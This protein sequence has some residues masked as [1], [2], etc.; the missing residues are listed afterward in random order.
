MRKLELKKELKQFYQPS[1]K[2]VSL[3]DVPKFNFIKIDGAIEKGM[4]PGN[5]P[6]Y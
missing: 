5:S 2:K 1:A 4:E 3:V 6:V